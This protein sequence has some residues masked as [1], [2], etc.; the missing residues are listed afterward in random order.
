[1]PRPPLDLA[2]FNGNYDVV[3]FLFAEV[4]KKCEGID[5][6]IVS[7]LERASELCEEYE[8]DETDEDESMHHILCVALPAEMW[9]QYQALIPYWFCKKLHEDEY[10][11]N[12]LV[13]SETSDWLSNVVRILKNGGPFHGIS[14]DYGDAYLVCAENVWTPERTEMVVYR[15]STR[16]TGNRWDYHWKE[17]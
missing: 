7:A 9:A 11:M 16:A 1:M 3:D 6:R 5:G 10:A 4:C 17:V 2:V 14:N 8:D 15:I 12:H 13:G